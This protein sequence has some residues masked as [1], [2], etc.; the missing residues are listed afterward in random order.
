MQTEER[1]VHLEVLPILSHYS[2]SLNQSAV[3][4][5]NWAT[6]IVP[7]CVVLDEPKLE[8]FLVERVLEVFC[9]SISLAAYVT[10]DVP[11]EL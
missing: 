7:S 8:M 4:W 5:T 1:E 6:V 11:W 10:K 2:F 9:K 3:R